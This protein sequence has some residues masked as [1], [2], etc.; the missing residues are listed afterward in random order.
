[1]IGTITVPATGGATT[2]K[3]M[4]VSISKVTQV[5]DVYLTF[6]GGTG[7]GNV[8]WFKFS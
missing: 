3:T 8:S 4:S 2:F 7:V 6:A 1:V 5:H